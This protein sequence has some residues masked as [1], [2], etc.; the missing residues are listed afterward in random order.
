MRSI[1]CGSQAVTTSS[2]AR[3]GARSVTL[4]AK[5]G[6]KTASNSMTGGNSL[7]AFSRALARRYGSVISFTM[8]FW[9]SRQSARCST[10]ERPTSSFAMGA[11]LARSGS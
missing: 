5:S 7:R 11:K 2:T 9:T 3:A 8:A 6:T 10:C 4:R 1:S